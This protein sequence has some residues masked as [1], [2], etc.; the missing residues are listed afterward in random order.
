VLW[1]NRNDVI[2]SPLET[3]PDYMNDDG[4]SKVKSV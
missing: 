2:V 4:S 3:C 1:Y